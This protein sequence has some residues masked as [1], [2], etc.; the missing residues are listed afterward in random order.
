MKSA[1]SERSQTYSQQLNSAREL[2]SKWAEAGPALE[3]LKLRRLQELDDETARK[4]TLDLF[5]LWRPREFDDL[6]AGLVAQQTLFAK[7]RESGRNHN[8]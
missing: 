4:M 6:G 5:S 8:Q 1:V 7:L 2:V 3:E